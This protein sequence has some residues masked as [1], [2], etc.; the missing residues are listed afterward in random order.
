M[1]MTAYIDV[2]SVPVTY[3]RFAPVDLGQ[4]RREVIS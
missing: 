4:A 3:I 2:I 1:I